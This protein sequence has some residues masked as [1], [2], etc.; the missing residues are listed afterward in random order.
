MTIVAV[1]SIIAIAFSGVNSYFLFVNLKSDQ[2]IQNAISEVNDRINPIES[3]QSALSNQFSENF[4]NLISEIAELNVR[5]EKLE[6][7]VNSTIEVLESRIDSLLLNISQLNEKIDYISIES[8]ESRL[9]SLLLDVSQLNERIDHINIE[10]LESMIENMK[11]NITQLSEKIDLKTLSPSDVYDAVHKSVVVIRT[12]LGQGSG[13]II[14]QSSTKYILTNWHVVESVSEIDIEFYDRTRSTAI[15]IGTDAYSDVAV[16][17]PLRTPLDSQP[18]HLGNSSNLIIGQEVVAI[19]NPLGL[20]GSLSSGIISQLNAEIDLEGVPIIVPVIQI[21]LTIAPGSSGG[22]L[23]DLEG[24]VIGIT[25]AGTD[26][27]YNF[28]VPSNMVRKVFSSIIEKGFYSHPYFGFNSL[29]LTPE[30]IQFYNIMGIDPSQKGMMILS[31]IEGMP[32]ENAGLISA[33][34]SYN[35]DN[36]INYIIVKDIILAVNDYKI[37]DYFDWNIYVEENVSPGQHIILTVLRSGETINIEI[38]PTFRG[39]YQE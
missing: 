6:F 27:G 17:M 7:N 19:G 25:N 8:L 31:L 18:L 38:T 15:V 3:E 22:A 5:T 39:Q 26:Y 33:N 37:I 32:A 34:I 20:E 9:D 36:T 11:T 14:E 2:E 28:A 21:D 1:I 23:V 4:E 16:I 30:L 10:A 24:N 13:F 35:D 29:A 12:D